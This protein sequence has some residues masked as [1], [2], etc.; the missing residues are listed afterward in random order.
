[1]SLEKQG[2]KIAQTLKKIVNTTI[3]ASYNELRV[4]VA[5]ERAIARLETEEKLKKHLVFKGGFVLL[6]TISSSRFTRDLDAQA[7]GVGRKEIV[8]L[9]QQ[10]LKKDLKDGLWY[11]EV[12]IEELRHVQYPGIRFKVPFQIGA[13]P[14]DAAGLK[15]LTKIDIDIAIDAKPVTDFEIQYEEMP[16]VLAE[17]PPVSWS[18]YPPEHIFSEK[19]EALMSR[20]S[21]SSRAKDV[22]DLIELFPR[23]KNKQVLLEI[24]KTTFFNRNT[25]LPDSFYEVASAF[26]VSALKMAWPNIAK[27]TGRGRFEEL[28]GT[29]LMVLKELDQN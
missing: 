26:D 23:C 14:P 15:K 20:G 16:S 7:L 1:M 13:P 6:K 28:W 11:G 24:I 17:W 25:K 19:L 22:Y 18:V 29:L 21:A 4:I 5:I 2:A 8:L 12:A 9:V 3:G 27:N 10:A